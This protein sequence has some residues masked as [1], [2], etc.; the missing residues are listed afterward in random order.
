M[1]SDPAPVTSSRRSFLRSVAVVGAGVGA[2]N[3]LGPFAAT[4]A[5]AAD[6]T[7]PGLLHT[8]SGLATLRTRSAATTGQWASG[9]AALRSHP[10]SQPGRSPRPVA[11]L[12]TGGPD[13]NF[14]T[15]LGDAHAAY[16]NALLWKITGEAG[17]GDTART[18]LDAWGRTLTSVVGSPLLGQTAGIYGFVLANAAELVRDHPEFDT[19]RF[20][21]MLSD[22]LVPVSEAYLDAE[23]DACGPSYAV[24]WELSHLASV[25][26]IG[27][28]RDDTAAL[29]RVTGALADTPRLMN[30]IPYG[31]DGGDCDRYSVTGLGL[32][33]AICETAWNQGR[34]LYAAH[35]DRLLAAAEEMAR[36]EPEPSEGPPLGVWGTSATSP[37]W[38]ILH[39][40]YV[41]RRGLA[42]PQTALLADRARAEGGGFDLVG[43]GALAYH[44]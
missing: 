1:S 38:A 22:V 36:H 42:A 12:D 3:L 16:Q 18:V 30:A 41:T 33:A 6:G 43:L 31:W 44:P 11:T 19:A 14:P 35:D 17:Y 24:N 8:T 23:P 21:T 9:W 34:D 32:L 4:P 7:H 2:A 29:D 25:Q 13:E 5:R 20:G 10:E 28:F 26:A 40:H 15:L 27:V 37:A 39:D